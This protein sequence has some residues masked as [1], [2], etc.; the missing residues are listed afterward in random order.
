[1]AMPN[2]ETEKTNDNRLGNRMA[3]GIANEDR[4]LIF[5]DARRATFLIIGT[6]LI[7]A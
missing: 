4:S 5:M 2:I 6:S 7:T 3:T 1:M